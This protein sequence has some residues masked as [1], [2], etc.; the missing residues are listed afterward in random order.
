[1]LPDHNFSWRDG[2]HFDGWC[3]WSKEMGRPATPCKL[4]AKRVRSVRCRGGNMK[5]R[6]LRLDSGNYAW[7]SAPR[8]KEVVG[9][10]FLDTIKLT[11]LGQWSW[12]SLKK[13]SILGLDGGF[14]YFVPLEALFWGRIP[15]WQSCWN[16]QLV[17]H[18]R[19]MS[20][21]RWGFWMCLWRP[22]GGGLLLLV[23]TFDG[24]SFLG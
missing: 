18:L 11:G 12:F 19:R 1:M 22:D 5:Y 24:T 20:P 14:K 17:G 16:H 8:Q 13:T 10:P 7:G 6:A 3:F 21:R 2:L 23:G 4:G 9:W 15:L